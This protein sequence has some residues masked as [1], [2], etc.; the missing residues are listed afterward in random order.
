MQLLL[1]RREMRKEVA[2]LRRV[3]DTRV[4]G[5]RLP[6]RRSADPRRVGP[7]GYVQVKRRPEALTV[8]VVSR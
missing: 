1:V 8:R 6:S 5:D 3:S 2:G 7:L 4:D